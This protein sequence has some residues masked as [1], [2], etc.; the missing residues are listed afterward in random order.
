MGSPDPGGDRNVVCL[1]AP[2]VSASIGAAL[3]KF[4]F[5]FG[6]DWVPLRGGEGRGHQQTSSLFATKWVQPVGKTEE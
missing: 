6:D 4:P 1:G 5:L 3:V 2:K